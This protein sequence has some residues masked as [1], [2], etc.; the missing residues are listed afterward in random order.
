MRY[1]VKRNGER[2]PFQ[3]DKI[4]IAISKANDEMDDVRDKVDDLQIQYIVNV[5]DTELNNRLLNSNTLHVEDIQ[6]MV[7]D[8]LM[9]FGKYKLS[10][11]YIRYRHGRELIRRANT[12][13][14]SVLSLIDL[15]NKEVMEENSNK[16]AHIASTQRDLIAGEVSKDLTWRKLLPRDIVEAHSEGILHFHGKINNVA[17][18]SDVY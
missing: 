4:V 12:T 14:D 1:I 15:N 8:G 2:T 7:E 10:R 18:H 9:G 11:A 3:R 17:L 6:D 16:A 5:I 13:D